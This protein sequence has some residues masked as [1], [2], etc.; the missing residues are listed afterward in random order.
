MSVF[1][2]P[3]LILS[4]DPPLFENNDDDD[5]GVLALSDNESDDEY[6]IVNKETDFA[7][8][9]ENPTTQKLYASFLAIK[10]GLRFL[11]SLDTNKQIKIDGLLELIDV[12]YKP[13]F[14]FSALLCLSQAIPYDNK[15]A[16][17]H[18]HNLLDPKVRDITIL[19]AGSKELYDVLQATGLK[20][21]VKGTRIPPG[22]DFERQ[23]FAKTKIT[24][25]CDWIEYLKKMHKPE[26]LTTKFIEYSQAM[27][28]DKPD[29]FTTEEHILDENNDKKILERWRSHNKK[30]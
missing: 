16:R 1:F 24:A 2:T 12:E 28:T 4:L 10:R 19:P 20:L 29:F 13:A 23:F 26:I 21:L 9:K 14:G 15:E 27:L 7:H 11:Q 25:L 17:A 18:L 22:C 6:E 30:T 8:V 5:F 3:F